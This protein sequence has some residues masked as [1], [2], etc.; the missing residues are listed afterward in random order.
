M[1]Q[2]LNKTLTQLNL[3]THI[4]KCGDVFGKMDF[5]ELP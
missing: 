3:S 5:N 2:K 4:Y 1:K